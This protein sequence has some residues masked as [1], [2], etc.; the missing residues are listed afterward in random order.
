MNAIHNEPRCYHSSGELSIRPKRVF[1]RGVADDD[2]GGG[3]ALYLKHGFDFNRHAE[4]EGVC[5]DGAA[6]ADAGLGPKD[7]GK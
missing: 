6:G 1:Y 4:R 5:A 2:S 7:V 3:L